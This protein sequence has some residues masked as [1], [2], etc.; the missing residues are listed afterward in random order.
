MALT[1]FNLG[2]FKPLMKKIAAST[3]F[4][5]SLD[6]LRAIRS[7]KIGAGMYLLTYIFAIRSIKINLFE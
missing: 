2:E 1:D 7:L 6:A 5:L 4:D 3:D